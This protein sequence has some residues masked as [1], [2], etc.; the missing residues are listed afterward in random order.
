MRTVLRIVA[1][2]VALAV[3]RTLLMV[4]HFASTG[5]FTALV[6]LGSFGIVTIAAWFIILTTGPIASI[7]LWRLRPLGLLMTV[8][9]SILAF[10]Y[11]VVGLFLWR[12]PEALFGPIVW[13]IALNAA[14]LALLLSPAA[15]R[16]CS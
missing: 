7:Q 15:R 3:V 14:F 2:L 6:R 11:Y 4:V 13:A 5:G 12:R 8:I 16:T 1:V 10:I 9:L